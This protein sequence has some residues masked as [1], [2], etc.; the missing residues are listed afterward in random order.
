MVLITILGPISGA[1]LNPAVS[2]ALAL[3]RELPLGELFVYVLVQIA[4]GWSAVA[5]AH[6][7]FD[8]PLVQVERHGAHRHGPVA[9]RDHRRVRAA[10][11]DLRLRPLQSCRGA[12]VRGLY[13]TAAYWFTSSTSFAN[14][15]VTI[16]RGLSD[17]FAGIRPIDVPAFIVAQLVGALAASVV[18]GLAVRGASTQARGG[19]HRLT[20]PLKERFPFTFLQTFP[21]EFRS[22][23]P[24]S[25]RPI[26]R[27]LSGMAG[28]CRCRA[29]FTRPE[30]VT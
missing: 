13:I 8:L 2:A 28:N 22:S 4:G 25:S 11:D 3:R 30:A 9:R 6:G 26:R 10:A 18:L 29:G 12:L 16:T 19:G 20:A 15:A 21:F 23:D 7:M 14:P 1:H 24:S 27:G 5:L 17:T